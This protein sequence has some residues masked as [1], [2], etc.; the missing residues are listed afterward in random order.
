MLGFVFVGFFFPL[1]LAF[2]NDWEMW[3][4][5]LN[6]K[7]DGTQS[8]IH[9]QKV[10]DICAVSKQLLAHVESFNLSFEASN[11]QNRMGTERRKADRADMQHLKERRTN[12]FQ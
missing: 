12:H 5:C 9:L 8:T 4:T 3:G 10:E 11:I 7:E 1:V 2:W 6:L